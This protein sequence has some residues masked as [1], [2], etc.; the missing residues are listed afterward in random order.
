[1]NRLEFLTAIALLGFTRAK[2]PSMPYHR[3][4]LFKLIIY[5]KV[6]TEFCTICIWKDF[7]IISEERKTYRD[8]Y[9]T[10]IKYLNYTQE[11]TDAL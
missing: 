3:I 9:N 4:N 10:I 8:T 7:H 1:M 5:I 2:P 11:E 6:N